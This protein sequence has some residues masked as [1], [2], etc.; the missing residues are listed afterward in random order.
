MLGQSRE[1]QQTSFFDVKLKSLDRFPDS[2][3]RTSLS[4]RNHSINTVPTSHILTLLYALLATLL[5]FLVTLHCSTIPF[6]CSFLGI[7]PAILN[8]MQ[9]CPTDFLRKFRG[10]LRFWESLQLFW[11]FEGDSMRHLS[12]SN[13]GN[14]LIG[15]ALVTE[16]TGK[17]S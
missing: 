7:L 1:F 8:T 11:S 6:F 17:S 15:S 12:Y 4:C 9:L 13:E 2:R 14:A 3:S 16:S 5:I 10:R